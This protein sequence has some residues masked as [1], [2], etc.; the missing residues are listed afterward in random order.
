MARNKISATKMQYPSYHDESAD[1]VQIKTPTNPGNTLRIK[2]DHMETIKPLSENQK[3]FMDAYN[4]GD[5]FIASHGCAGTGKCIGGN[6][7]ITLL[8]DDDIYEK[9]TK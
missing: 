2:L 9:L 5:Y 6:E 7:L 3:L 1:V 4:R 8:V